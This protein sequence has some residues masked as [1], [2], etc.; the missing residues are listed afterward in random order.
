[1]ICYIL[2]LEYQKKYFKNVHFST[3]SKNCWELSRNVRV[4]NDCMRFTLYQEILIQIPPESRQVMQI[5]IKYNNN[6]NKSQH[7]V[8]VN[9]NHHLVSAAM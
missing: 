2:R 8:V 6:N 3:T 7:T 4:R 5:R 1:M 9:D